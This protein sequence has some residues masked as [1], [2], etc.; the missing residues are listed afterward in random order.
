MCIMER[1]IHF[2]TCLSVLANFFKIKIVGVTSVTN[3]IRVSS[4]QS[5][6]TKLAYCVVCAPPEV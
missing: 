2:V 3:M 4:V 5:Y 6:S 1:E